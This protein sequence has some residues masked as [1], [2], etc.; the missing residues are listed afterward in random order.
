MRRQKNMSQMK[1][2]SKTPEKELSKIETSNLPDA[3][4]K[5]CS[6]NIS[7]NFNKKIGN[8]KMEIEN[9]KKNQSEMKNTITEM[10]NY[11]R[12]NQQIG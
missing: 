10:K 5:G 4:L 7:E 11:I 9:I 8:I 12:G 1:E 2:E 3:E 6:V